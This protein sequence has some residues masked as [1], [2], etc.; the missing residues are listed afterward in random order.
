MLKRFLR[1]YIVIFFLIYR[2]FCVV[3]IGIGFYYAYHEARMD[4]E[5]VAVEA[6]MKDNVSTVMAN[7]NSQGQVGDYTVQ[8]FYQVEGQE[9]SNSFTVS[10]S[11]LDELVKG[12]S[13]K[14]EVLPSQPDWSRLPGN[15]G[16]WPA[17]LFSLAAAAMLAFSFL[18]KR[19][20]NSKMAKL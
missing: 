3:A 17:L 2:L 16:V 13:Q 8:L 11:T 1:V 7:A 19:L 20:M 10:Y 12:G 15:S 9:Y 5:A 4:K 18:V 14:L 6:R